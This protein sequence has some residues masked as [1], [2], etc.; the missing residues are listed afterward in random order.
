M[1]H[2]NFPS[3]KNT[4]GSKRPRVETPSPTQITSYDKFFKI[5][6]ESGSFKNASPFVIFK[7]L[8]GYFGKLNDIKK[9]S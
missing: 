8:D 2:N 5:K 7:A 1:L 6:L 9:T 4:N 3:L